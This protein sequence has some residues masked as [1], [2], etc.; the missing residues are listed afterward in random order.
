MTDH[1]DRASAPQ[2]TCD[3]PDCSGEAVCDLISETDELLARFCSEH[4]HLAMDGG[5]SDA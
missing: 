1:E 5:R 4:A 2:D 3:E